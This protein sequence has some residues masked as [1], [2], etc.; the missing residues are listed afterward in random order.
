[1]LRI[2]FNGEEVDQNIFKNFPPISGF[3]F[4]YPNI[5]SCNNSSICDNVYQFVSW[6]VSQLQRISIESGVHLGLVESCNLPGVI[7][8][9]NL[10]WNKNTDDICKRAFDRMWM[11]RRLKALDANNNEL[12][13]V[14]NWFVPKTSDPDNVQTRSYPRLQSSSR[15]LGQAHGHSVTP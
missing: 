3:K 12:I 15:D 7:I 6:S 11:I 13:D 9:S 1:M 5:F 14:D 8:Q 10:K 4:F 2:A